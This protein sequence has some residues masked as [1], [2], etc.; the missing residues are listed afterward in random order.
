M[1]SRWPGRSKAGG[2]SDEQT[3]REGCKHGT[4]GLRLEDSACGLQRRRSGWIATGVQRAASRL[5]RL[6]SSD[7]G[8]QPYKAGREKARGQRPRLQRTLQKKLPNLPNLPKY[9]N[10]ILGIV[11][12]SGYER[13][14]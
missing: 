6:T 8:I 9:D 4:T 10:S 5:T 12:E 3:P 2:K 11:R 13:K 14:D 7:S 1:K